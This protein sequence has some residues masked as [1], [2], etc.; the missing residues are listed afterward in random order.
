MDVTLVCS[1]SW[2][3]RACSIS[4]IPKTST[5]WRNSWRRRSWTLAN[6]SLML[7]VSLLPR[8]TW[9]TTQ[10]DTVTNQHRRLAKIKV[11]QTNNRHA[12]ATNAAPLCA[13]GVQVQADAPIRPSHLT[14]GG[15]RSFF[16]RMKHGR[17]AGKQED[18]HSLPSTSKKKGGFREQSRLWEPPNTFSAG[19]PAGLIMSTTTNSEGKCWFLLNIQLSSVRNT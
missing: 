7:Q 13:A 3:G 12:I 15:R 6:A 4:S 8:Q 11:K 17:V 9:K 16:C 14:T 18:K 19:A 5:R 10:T 2:L 1:W